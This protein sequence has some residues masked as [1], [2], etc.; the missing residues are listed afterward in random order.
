[1]GK[2][3][4]WF[5]YVLLGGIL[6]KVFAW[7]L[8][9]KSGRKFWSNFSNLAIAEKE[10]FTK[11]A[12][13]E[14]S[15]DELMVGSGSLLKDYFIPGHHNDCQPKILRTK[16]LLYIVLPLLACKLLLAGYLFWLYPN[17]AQMSQQISQELSILVNQAR[18]DNGLQP[19]QPNQE[20]EQAAWTK[21]QD[22][23]TQDYFNHLGFDGKKPWEWI[24]DSRYQYELVGENLATNFASAPALFAVLFNNEKSRKN[25]LNSNYQDTGLAVVSGHLQGQ[26][27]NI[28]VQLLAKQ[29]PIATA[30][31]SEPSNQAL[32]DVE[33]IEQVLGERLVGPQSEIKLSPNLLLE[34]QSQSE[35][36]WQSATDGKLVGLAKQSIVWLRWLYLVAF[37][38]LALALFLNI[39]IRFKQQYRHLIIQTLLA[40]LILGGLCWW[41]WHLLEN[42][43]GPIGLL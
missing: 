22:I 16:S 8:S 30:T 40:L 20:L 5:K 34:N 9:T 41:P 25:L 36:I 10:E 35:I 4:T 14:E 37:V 7:L 11:F 29:Q 38:I 19:L 23:I 21:A 32:I 3:R 12:Q 42:L 43:T 1:M 39:V 18:L 24:D 27:T 6:F 33:P 17:P 13:Q 28:L 15:L 2:T 26:P 31:V